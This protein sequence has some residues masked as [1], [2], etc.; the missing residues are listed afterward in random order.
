VNKS[1]KLYMAMLLSQTCSWIISTGLS[2]K[3]RGSNTV[4]GSGSYIS[5]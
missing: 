5:P 2:L 1:A 4:K 3:F